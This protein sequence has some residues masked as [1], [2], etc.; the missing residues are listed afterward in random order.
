[1]TPELS[2]MREIAASQEACF[3]AWTDPAKLVAWFGPRGV[4]C[5]AAEVDLRA[6][7]A[8]RLDNRLP[9]GKVVTIAGIYEAVEPPV[10]LVYTWRIGAEPAS[11][12]TVTFAALAPNR[13]RVEIVHAQIADLAT[14]D[15]HQAGWLGC[16]DRFAELLA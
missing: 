2:V 3:A 6:G 5:I 7:G 10:R 1:V 14:R 4:T 16:L 12:V 11:R 8:Y 13:T 9:D 15:D